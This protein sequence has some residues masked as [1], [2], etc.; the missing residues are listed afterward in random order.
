VPV[1]VSVYIPFFAV[2][3]Y[4]YDWPPRTQRRAIGGLFAIDAAM[5][6]V[7]ILLGWI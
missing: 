5:L 3:F 4:A 1:F 2:A 7:F 6:V